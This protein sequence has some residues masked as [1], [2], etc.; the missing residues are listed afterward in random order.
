MAGSPSS[1]QELHDV[2]VD[3]GTPIADALARMDLAGTGGLALCTADGKLV[4]F[5]TDGDI[6]RAVL[7]GIPLDR[8]CGG[9]ANH[10]PVVAQAPVSDGE[11][12]HLMRR[13]DVNQLPVVDAHGVLLR[14]LLLTHLATR[15]ALEEA[16]ARR[17]EGVIIA[18]EATIAEAIEQLDQAG[19]GTLV[20]CAPG[21]KLQG[22]LTDGDLRRAIMQGVSLADSCET[23]AIPTP[24]TAEA[25]VTMGEALDLM[26]EHDVDQLPVVDR[27][28]LLTDLLLRRDIAVDDKP[29][30]SAVIM[31]GGLGKRLLPLTEHVPKPMLPVGDRPLLERTIKQLKRSGIRDVSM[32]TRY[33]QE[34]ITQHFGDGSEFGVHIS[35]TKEDQPL[36][37]AGG[38]RL[39]ER[40]DGPF[41]VIN[42][43]I[44]TGVSFEKMLEYH[45]QHAAE[46]TVGVRRYEID[47]PFGVVECDDVHITRLREKPSLSLFINAGIYLLEPS[48]LDFIPA[49]EH[50]DMTDLI[51][52]LLDQGRAVVSFPIIEYWLDIGRPEDYER[53]QDE[54]GGGLG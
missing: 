38:L 37:T 25:P 43:D 31:A 45:R 13:H 21:R 40:P 5:L 22:L 42:G 11:A 33:L 6:R 14:L 53:A 30:L 4:G 24:L 3:P 44:L 12:L 23:I 7:R 54:L 50:F 41:V 34:N 29:A 36:G 47:V 17:L 32:T 51:E 27:Q 35:Y 49:G 52:R 19:T 28:G 16:A 39:L 48:A 2:I 1:Q 46:L 18:P 15:E 9:I 26:I 10:S 8:P 20:V